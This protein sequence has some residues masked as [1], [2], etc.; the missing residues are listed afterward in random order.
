MAEIALVVDAKRLVTR[1]PVN[2]DTKNAKEIRK[3][4]KQSK[5]SLV[6]VIKRRKNIVNQESEGINLAIYL[7][8]EFRGRTFTFKGLKNKYFALSGENLL[9]RIQEELDSMLILYRYTT[10]AK[11]Y[12]DNKGIPQV[13]IN[14]L[15]KASTMNRYNPLDIELDIQT[16]NVNCSSGILNACI[17]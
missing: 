13:E 12:I 17:L 10:K 3:V 14:L 4:K 6:D 9:K 16:E 8:N 7:I 2:S 11:K 1:N 15:G 5:M